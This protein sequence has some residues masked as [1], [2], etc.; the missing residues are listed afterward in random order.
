MQKI[1][2]EIVRG[3]SEWHMM[4]LFAIHVLGFPSGNGPR[5]DEKQ[6]G[7]VENFSQMRKALGVKNM[8]LAYES[9]VKISNYHGSS[10][11]ESVTV[12]RL[13]IL[14]EAEGVIWAF[15]PL[16]KEDG[17]MYLE[18]RYPSSG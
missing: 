11:K 10:P 17:G 15:G 5:Y 2:F 9:A 3:I 14:I 4:K 1:R 8:R 16:P 18:V 12:E 13:E 7:F 6:L